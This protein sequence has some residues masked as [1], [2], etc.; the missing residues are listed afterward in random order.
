MQIELRDLSMTYP[1]GKQV[2][3]HLNLSLKAP[4]LIGLLGPNGAGK[5]TLMNIITDNIKPDA[6]SKVLYNGTPITKLGESYRAVLG[7]MPQQQGLYDNYT[8]VRFL[9]YIASLKGI[10]RT[11]GRAQIKDALA[12][13]ELSDVAAKRVG[14]FSGGMKQRLLIA[15]AILGNPEVIILDEPTAGVDPRQRVHIRNLIS[16]LAQNKI[17]IVS[18][19][20]VSDVETIADRVLLLKDGE[21]AVS[22]SVEEL[23]ASL[24]SDVPATLENVYMQY[25]GDG[26]EI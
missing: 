2:L 15:Q 14:G 6:G 9:G 1:N 18:T 16:R 19:H 11:E 21:L 22:G 24:P 3:Q 26:D 23:T 10:K 12:Q 8:A 25:F 5:S 7:Y 13:V 20:I 17:V 4:S